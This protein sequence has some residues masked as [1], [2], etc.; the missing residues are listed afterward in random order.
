MEMVRVNPEN[1]K[2]LQIYETIK[3]NAGCTKKSIES[4]IW[5][6]LR[7]FAEFIGD[8][9][10]QKVTMLD[11]EEF[12]THC[13]T[14]RKNSAQAV[15]RKQNS[16]NKF[17]NTMIK[18]E[19]FDMK[20]PLD[21]IEKIKFEPKPRGYLSKDEFRQ[22]VRYLKD[23]QN[24]RGLAFVLLTY[25]SA[26]RIS[27]IIR[28]NRDSL[29]YERQ[30][31]LILGKGQ[32]Y[33][34]CIFSAEAGQ[35]VRDYLVT[36]NDDHPALFYSREHTRLSKESHEWFL[37]NAAKTAGIRK[38]VFPHLLRHTRAMH[39][40]EDGVPLDVI[41]KILGHK[42]ISTT[43]IYAVTSIEQAQRTVSNIDKENVWLGR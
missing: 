42:N 1:L 38:R 32:R 24:L 17:F 39:L 7:L 22:L 8:L 9:P 27:E 11:V 28:L 36:R 34:H 15:S 26:C 18:R 5:N 2:Y 31:F 14:K 35:A 29:D 3:R 30:Q 21:K 4:I 23:T 16:L 10:F 33:R 25:S 20:N 12:F 37:R 41:Q 13:F 6:D 19:Y 43:Q 40:L